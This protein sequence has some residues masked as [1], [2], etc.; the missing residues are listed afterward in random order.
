MKPD[1]NV[2]LP[3]GRR[4]VA[5]VLVFALVGLLGLLGLPGLAL[6]K[7]KPAAG[8]RAVVKR[9]V[10][11]PAPR[12][13]VVRE[14]PVPTYTR[15]GQPN[16]QARAALVVDL[17]AGGAPLYQKNPDEVRPIASI[18]KLMAMLVVLE[19]KLS[20]DGK[21]IDLDARTM[22]TPEDARLTARGAKSRLLAGMTL[23]NRDLLHAALMG[24]DNRAV[25]ALGRAAG[26]SPA[27]FAAEMSARAKALGLAHTQFM[28][29]TGLNYGNVST[30]R[31]VIQMLQAAL[32]NP[33]IA[34]ACRSKQYVAHSLTRPLG[35]IEYA[36]TDLLL[37]ASKHHIHGGKTGYNDRAGYCFVV[38]ARL[39]LPGTKPREVAMAFLGDEGK[40]TRFADFG[41]AAQWMAEKAP[42]L[43]AKADSAAG[44]DKAAGA[45]GTSGAAG[46]PGTSG[47]GG[48]AGARGSVGGPT[49]A[50]TQRTL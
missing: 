13:R 4:G 20:A 33:L 32:K 5:R 21:R 43:T 25:L 2:S 12:R 40:L 42:K 9:V 50:A 6:A 30:P 1:R 48:S 14:R 39:E 37:R 16:I 26:M 22:I 44:G 15:A 47:A 29:P 34:S 3:D 36:N 27:Q 45:N 24:S 19:R 7:A 35:A 38:A 17:D 31:E 8:K 28:D 23:T 18:S 11:R 10:K 46:T 41:R 49:V